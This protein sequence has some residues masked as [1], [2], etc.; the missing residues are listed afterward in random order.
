MN[1]TNEPE[2]KKS[3][4]NNIDL[5]SKRALKV[6]DQK[7]FKLVQISNKKRNTLSV[8]ELPQYDYTSR[9]NNKTYN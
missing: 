8:N 7:H 9:L 1:Y 5:L 2:E 4:L 3:Y 6:I